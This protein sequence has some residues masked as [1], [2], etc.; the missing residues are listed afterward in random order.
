MCIFQIRRVTFKLSSC[1][2]E[3]VDVFS[4][5][6]QYNVII[7]KFDGLLNRSGVEGAVG[8]LSG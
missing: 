3:G 6:V 8:W 1:F 5:H 7:T 2:K 4:Y